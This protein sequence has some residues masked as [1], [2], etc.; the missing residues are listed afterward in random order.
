LP[1]ESG[2]FDAAISVQTLEYVLEVNTA[3]GELH[4]AL[5]PGG[6]LVIWDVDWTT[7]SWH[8]AQPE[9]MERVLRVWDGHLAHPALPRTI[10]TQLRRNGFAEVGA[11]G[12]PFVAQELSSD[13]YIGAIFSLVEAYVAG[14]RQLPAD[15]VTA[16]AAE[17]RELSERGEFFFAVIQFCFTATRA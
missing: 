6:R 7:L 10:T 12:H 8:S 14:A 13:A 16:W 9:R 4:R 1:V 3:L 2:Q 11:E 17:Q 5:R 15:A